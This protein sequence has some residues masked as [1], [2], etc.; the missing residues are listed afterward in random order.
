MNDKEMIKVQDELIK[1][2]YSQVVD[3][4]IMSKIELGDDVIAEI[5]R[6][7]NL[8]SEYW[9]RVLLL[10]LL[11]SCSPKNY[12][13]HERNLKIQTDGMIK[14]DLIMKKKMGKLRRQG[15]RSYSKFNKS[16]YKLER[17]FI[18][19]QLKEKN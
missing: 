12:N 14:Q 8:M 19:S 10:V 7:R 4:S 17:K 16:R 13:V 15:V 18:W 1:V 3:L 9:M 5:Q 6:L 2:L 11:L